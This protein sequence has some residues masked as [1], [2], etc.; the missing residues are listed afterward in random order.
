MENANELIKQNL[1]KLAT[2][3]QKMLKVEKDIQ[4]LKI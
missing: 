4:D 3:G 1:Q 2:S